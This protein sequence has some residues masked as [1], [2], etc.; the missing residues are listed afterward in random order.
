MQRLFPLF[1][2]QG[3]GLA[4]LALR[5]CVAGTLFG[6]V[7]SATLSATAIAAGAAAA[8][9]ALG[10][11]T[12]AAALAALVLQVSWAAEREVGWTVVAGVQAGCVMLLG[13][14][15]WSLDAARFGRRTLRWPGDEAGHAG[16]DEA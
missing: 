14:G 1:P 10:A 11:F 4:L 13:P 3:A 15:G 12:P 5:L 9:L 6:P 2:R 7:A 16:K 8:L